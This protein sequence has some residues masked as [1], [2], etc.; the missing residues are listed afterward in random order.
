M[1]AKKK[2]TTNNPVDEIL[3]EDIT[4]QQDGQPQTTTDSTTEQQGTAGSQSRQQQ[5]SSTNTTNRRL[6]SEYDNIIETIDERNREIDDDRQETGSPTGTAMRIQDNMM[7]F[8]SDMMDQMQDM[9]REIREIREEYRRADLTPERV[10]RIQDQVEV[11]GRQNI[12]QRR[13]QEQRKL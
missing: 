1:G 9:R 10:Q 8:F 13:N 6:G 12:Q 4:E 3:T 11:G 5:T 2:T 7:I